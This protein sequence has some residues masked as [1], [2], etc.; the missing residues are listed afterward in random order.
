M[1]VNLHIWIYVKLIHHVDCAFG[2]VLDNLSSGH[3]FHL[4]DFRVHPINWNFTNWLIWVYFNSQ[5]ETGEVNEAAQ[6][7][8][9]YKVFD[10]WPCGQSELVIFG[11]NTTQ[12]SNSVKSNNDGL[13]PAMLKAEK[14][15]KAP[16]IVQPDIS[17]MTPF[18]VL[19]CICKEMSRFRIWHVI[20]GL[21]KFSAH[22]QMDTRWTS[23][24]RRHISHSTTCSWPCFKAS[25]SKMFRWAVRHPWY[26]P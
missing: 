17:Q 23:H 15:K 16:A 14:A 18:K 2:I 1:K 4:D 12:E 11:L 21:F 3:L 24:S 5:D 26:A 25:T 22:L 19:F 7:I 13:Q 8:E 20:F 6:L 10:L 9:R